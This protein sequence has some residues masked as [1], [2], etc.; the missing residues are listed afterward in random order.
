MNQRA[1]IPLFAGKHKAA[2]LLDMTP[3][4]FERL[5]SNGSLP[6]PTR[7]ERWDVDQLAAIM[8]G[9]KP[10]PSEEFDL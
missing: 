1:E 9:T 5:V 3:A 10:K 7:L 8:R 6:G 2:R 4:E